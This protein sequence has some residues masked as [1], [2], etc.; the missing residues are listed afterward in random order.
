MPGPAAD[1]FYFYCIKI[2]K[3]WNRNNRW[4]SGNSIT[5]DIILDLSHFCWDLLMLVDGYFWCLYTE[6]CRQ[7]GAFYTK[8]EWLKYKQ[9]LTCWN[10]FRINCRNFSLSLE[11][12]LISSDFSIGCLS[13][14]CF[15]GIALQTLSM[16]ISFQHSH[17]YKRIKLS[18]ANNGSGPRERERDR[19]SSLARSKSEAVVLKCIDTRR[20]YLSSVSYQYR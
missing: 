7:H 2:W 4:C 18:S 1:P 17:W 11:Y 8:L 15:N 6:W 5:I 9:Q 16:L 20:L 3:F 12:S 10:S 19:E 13:H 14:H